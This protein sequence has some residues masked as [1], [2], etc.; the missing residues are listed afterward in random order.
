MALHRKCIREGVRQILLDATAAG[1]RVTTNRADPMLHRSDISPSSPALAIYTLEEGSEILNDAP[2][3]YEKTLRV[4]IEGFLR[5][6]NAIQLDDEAELL[7]H[8]VEDA[9]LPR[10]HLGEENPVEVDTG[11]TQPNELEFEYTARGERLS[12][13]FR[14]AISFV[15]RQLEDETDEALVAYLNTLGTDWHLGVPDG[16]PDAEDVITLPQE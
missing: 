3:I 6:A 9:L 11:K 15:Y 1:A 14:L 16:T 10:L 4:G 5:K 12:G 13:A 2:R 7:A 8:Q